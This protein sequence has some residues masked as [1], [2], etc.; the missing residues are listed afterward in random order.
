METP[1][2]KKKT[3]EA[4]KSL[5]QW[6]QKLIRSYV[7]AQEDGRIWKYHYDFEE[8]YILLNMNGWDKLLPTTKNLSFKQPRKI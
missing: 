5:D 1:L 8:F 7:P 6:T 3:Q 2:K 4:F